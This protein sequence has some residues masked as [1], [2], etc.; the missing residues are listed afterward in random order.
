MSTCLSVVTM[1][2]LA[3]LPFLS[4]QT[5]IDDRPL[6][7]SGKKPASV[8]QSSED[9]EPERQDTWPE[10]VV[11]RE[12]EQ[13]M[14]ALKSIKADLEI[15]PPVKDGG[16][17]APALVRLKSVG[18]KSPLVFNPPVEVNCKLAAALYR[19]NKTTVQPAS[20]RHLRSRV[21]R[22]LGASGYA[23]RNVYNLPNRNLSQHAHANAIDVSAFQLR[24]GRIVTVRK[25]WGPTKRDKEREKKKKAVAAA[26]KSSKGQGADSKASRK[27]SG[28]LRQKIT[29]AGLNPGDVPV[30]E[31]SP[32]RT[33]PESAAQRAKRLATT[34]FFKRLHKGA[35]S[36]FETVL[37]PE[38][39]EAHRGHFHFDL[40]AGR[41]RPYCY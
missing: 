22:I 18:S 21:A 41:S 16:C 26:K 40:N 38:A 1:A 5:Q 27:F 34:K 2:G 28:R 35:C 10:T 33:E 12:K 9:A 15:L 6:A 36:Q 31:S 11:A 30:P 29:K 8:L 13:C 19:W 3:L 7:G 17:G 25:G 20:R 4:F 24:N 39:N 32:T 23:C 14:Q 37:G